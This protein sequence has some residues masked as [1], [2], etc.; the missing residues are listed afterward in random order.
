[1]GKGWG[2]RSKGKS[3][4]KKQV[5]AA[6]VRAA[7][8]ELAELAAQ[9]QRR[10]DQAAGTAAKHTHVPQHDGRGGARQKLDTEAMSPRSKKRVERSTAPPDPHPTSPT[11]HIHDPNPTGRRG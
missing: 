1:M 8:A 3:N 5:S 6:E 10:K 9:R 7:A 11:P 4:N 2:R